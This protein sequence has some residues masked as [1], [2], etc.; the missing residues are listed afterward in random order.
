MLWVAGREDCGMKHHPKA[1]N[2]E[3]L[4]EEILQ[5]GKENIR[6]VIMRKAAK[7]KDSLTTVIK[8]PFT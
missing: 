3:T 5:A 7:E 6:E 2:A 4:Q 8:K 1:S